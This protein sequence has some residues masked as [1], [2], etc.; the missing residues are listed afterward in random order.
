M[1]KVGQ[2][3]ELQIPQ[4][5]LIRYMIRR[6]LAR[7]EFERSLRIPDLGL[8]VGV[9]RIFNE[10][11]A[12]VGGLSFFIPIFDRRQ[13][14]LMR[15]KYTTEALRK[16]LERVKLEIR[17]RINSLST[18]LLSLHD[19]IRI[20][21]D[22]ILPLAQKNLQD[23][24]EGY[25]IGKFTII[26]VLHAQ[27]TLF[28]SQLELAELLGEFKTTQVELESILMFNEIRERWF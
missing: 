1:R 3:E 15:I 25:K 14:E 20:L 11:W 16:E 13:G 18:S 26:D 24:T 6:E 23:I 9:R 4:T 2:V 10:G 19:R 28:S 17:Q 27:N 21:D 8:A 7:Y 5:L 12:L 22:E